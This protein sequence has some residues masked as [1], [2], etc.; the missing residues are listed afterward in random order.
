MR[1]LVALLLWTLALTFSPHPIHAEDTSALAEKLAWEERYEEAAALLLP[2][3]VNEIDRLYARMTLC[4]VYSLWG[5]NAEALDTC[6]AGLSSFWLSPFLQCVHDAPQNGG[7]IPDTEDCNRAVTAYDSIL[8]LKVWL[9]LAYWR[10][11]QPRETLM[12]AADALVILHNKGG[13]RLFV[14]AVG[15]YI[16]DDF[17]RVKADYQRAGKDPAKLEHLRIILTYGGASTPAARAVRSARVLWAEQPYARPAVYTFGALLLCAAI[18][19]PARRPLRML[20]IGAFH[21][22][23]P[24]PRHVNRLLRMLA[25]GALYAATII[26]RR[27]NVWLHPETSP[28][29]ARAPARSD[30]TASAPAMPMYFNMRYPNQAYRIAGYCWAAFWIVLAGPIALALLLPAGTLLMDFNTKGFQNAYNNFLHILTTSVS[31]ARLWF[32]LL[33]FSLIGFTGFKLYGRFSL[34]KRMRPPIRVVYGT[35]RFVFLGTIL[36]SVGTFLSYF[37]AA[38][39]G[40]YANP[41]VKPLIAL[42]CKLLGF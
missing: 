34:P 3:P 18:Y 25:T 31:W 15:A 1:C 19:I 13:E 35:L 4:T 32:A 17:K 9:T 27:V 21:A 40:I 12:A 23:R 39:A 26:L 8:K 24:I 10:S 42:I 30:S 5:K 14:D 22:A 37:T 41:F 38:F 16:G 33:L 29:A 7:R 6:S 28:R 11:R 2:L 20:A 36:A